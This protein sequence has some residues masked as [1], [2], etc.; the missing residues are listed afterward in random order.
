MNSDGEASMETVQPIKLVFKN[1]TW[2]FKGLK[3]NEQEPDHVE[4]FKIS[5]ISQL[6]FVHE[7][8]LENTAAVPIEDGGN[9]NIPDQL[10]IELL[11]SASLAYRV[12]DFFDPAQIQQEPDGKLR[13]IVHLAEGERLYSFLMSFGADVTVIEPISVQKELLRRHRMAVEHLL[14]DS[15]TPKETE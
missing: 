13:V 6:R 4:T 5:R 3:R 9:E 15:N 2:Y 7:R 10:R 11:F 8:Y 1:N 14:A 12:K